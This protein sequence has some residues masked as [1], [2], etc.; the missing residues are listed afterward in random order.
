MKTAQNLHIV[1]V[2]VQELNPAPYNPR[3]WTDKAIKELTESIKRFGLVDPL[4]VNSAPNRKNVVIGGHFRLEV[5]KRLRHE[6]VPVLYI[7]IPDEVKEK[8][9][10]KEQLKQKLENMSYKI[11]NKYKETFN[12]IQSNFLCSREANNYGF[13]KKT[14]KIPRAEL[15]RALEYKKEFEGRKK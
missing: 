12:G 4:L 15:N 1:S 7:N 13:I 14:N 3:K 5:A 11:Y 6:S 10:D 9:V 2:S 8:E